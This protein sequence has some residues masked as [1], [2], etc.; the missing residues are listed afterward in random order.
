MTFALVFAAI[1]RHPFGAL[2]AGLI[3]WITAAL[4]GVPTSVAMGAWL[5]GSLLVFE[6]W[7]LVEPTLL[8]WFGGC[9]AAS[10][11]ER[12]RL[13]A[14]LGRTD[15]RLLVADAG[16]LAAVRGLRC[17]VVGRDVLDLFEDRALG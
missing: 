7:F 14:A 8:R 4:L 16:E 12:E 17:L 15:L 5:V 10:D 3:V 2:T 1:R 9:R 11:A 6:L 13:E